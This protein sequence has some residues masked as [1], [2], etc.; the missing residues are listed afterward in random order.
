MADFGNI[1][2]LVK[3]FTAPLESDG[4]TPKT[5][6]LWAKETV[7]LGAEVTL[8]RY[9][10]INS[11]W[12]PLSSEESVFKADAA[13]SANSLLTGVTSVDGVGLV[14]GSIVLLY[15][16]TVATENG[17]Y[18]SDGAGVLSRPDRFSTSV[19]GNHLIVVHN[20]GVNGGKMFQPFNLTNVAGFTVDTDPI[21]YK[22]VYSPVSA[23]TGAA[24]GVLS[25][26]ALVGSNL[27]FTGADGGFN[28]TVDL[29][30][31]SSGVK[32]TFTFVIG[33]FS[34]E[35]VSVTG[36]VHGKGV[37]PIVQVIDDATGDIVGVDTV[38]VNPANG[39]VTI[40]VGVG[41]EFNGRAIIL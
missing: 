40:T 16:Q 9:D 5:Y 22:A 30:A 24:D 25:A 28:G 20:G 41:L 36:A 27:N 13:D 32:Y 18:E 21:T 39:N 26:V 10:F 12:V 19:L 29:A 1:V 34:S 35:A 33:D 31:I 7:A 4:V 14:A 23:S 6:V 37:N 8:M 3:S 17:L 15:G 2:G 11:V 38:N